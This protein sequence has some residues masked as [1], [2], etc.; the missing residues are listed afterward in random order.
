MFRPNLA[1]RDIFSVTMLYVFDNGACFRIEFEDLDGFYRWNWDRIW[2]F[3]ALKISK[4]DLEKRTD[5][6]VQI[7]TM[8]TKENLFGDQNGE[9]GLHHIIF[10]TNTYNLLSI[11]FQYTILISFLYLR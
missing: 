4:K 1:I 9:N 6:L 8:A 2:Y 11:C 7:L 10:G 5:R 3:R